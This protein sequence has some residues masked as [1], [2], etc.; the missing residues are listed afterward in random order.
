MSKFG[1]A[2]QLFQSDGISGVISV[3]RA[4]IKGI[5]WSQ[6]KGLK[7][8]AA[9]IDG[10]SF[11]LTMP[12]V[13]SSHKINLLSGEYEK[14]ERIALK[15]FLDS[16]LPVIEFGGAMGVV[17]CITNKMLNNP[18]SHVV[19]E[20][21]PNLIS[22]LKKNRD[23]NGCKF[24]VINAM[25]GYGNDQSAFRI[26][27]EDFLASTSVEILN[28]EKEDITPHLIIP[29]VS[30]RSILEQFKFDSCTLICDIEGSEAEL[31]QHES[32]I[33]KQRVK[34]IIIEVHKWSLGEAKVEQML[35]DVEHLGFQKSFK[36]FETYV[37]E[38]RLLLT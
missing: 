20:A 1:T 13:K 18:S 2:L 31:I 33:L 30:L 21:N 8:S 19:V 26:N 36:F 22:I 6:V 32:A 38:N 3:C 29:T 16:S 28:K 35:A 12:F 9:E 34:T 7:A 15:Q 24:E 10:C 5:W 4:K 17:S 23:D 37:F 11:D 27:Q 14:A 25:V